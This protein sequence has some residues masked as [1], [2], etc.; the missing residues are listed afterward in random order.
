MKT[1]LLSIGFFILSFNV[2]GQRNYPNNVF[3][4]PLDIPLVLA[5]TFGELRNNH[6]HSGIDI[7]TKGSS[8]LPVYAIEEGYVS[9]IKITHGGYGKA[10]YVTHPN[11]FVSVY[12]H[13]SRYNE[14]IKKVARDR[15][16]EKE[17]YTIEV[18]PKAGTLPVKKGDIIAFTGNSGSST[19]P[20]LHFEIRDAVSQETINPLL[21]GFKVSDTK[22]PKINELF[23][24]TLEDN[25]EICQLHQ[26]VEL[27]KNN[28]QYKIK[29]NDTIQVAPHFG[30]ALHTIDHQNAATNKNGIYDIKLYADDELQYHYQMERF[31]FSETRYINSHIDYETK[32]KERKSIHKSFLDPNN[33]LSIYK[34]TNDSKGIIHF[35]DD[36]VHRIKYVVSDIHNNTSEL[37]FYVQQNFAINSKN[38]LNEGIYFD[39]NRINDF[40]R[41]ELQLYIPNK[42]LYRSMRFQ[43]EMKNSPKSCIAPLHKIHNKNT[44]LHKYAMLSMSID[45]LTPSLQEK[46]CIVKINED[47]TMTYVGGEWKNHTLFT[48]IRSFGDYSAS[49]D[50]VP[51]T[52]N[53]VSF[54][55]AEN[56]SN[57]RYLRIK[58][59]DDLS[60]IKSYK[61]YVD[62]EWVLMEYDSKKKQLTHQFT[63]TSQNKLKTFTLRLSDNRNNTTEFT[64][65]FIR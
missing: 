26:K 59:D 38:N 52:V 39:A 20:H 53:Y 25:G 56:L 35:N 41:D 29:A 32:Q 31:A 64:S 57:K 1:F 60:G 4:S 50:T 42:S 30:F 49:L 9:R 43:Y 5:G 63:S 15:Q 16:Y 37:E 28:Q 65:Q 11:G 10:L 44:P 18:F 23:V 47:N 58:I 8:G 13:L 40:H 17:S 19:A 2:F 62:D 45:S 48:K 27:Q 21:F 3:R 55:K 24:Y 6:F 46:A 36:K 12:A 22:A 33:K 61:A 54:K 7:K 51:P 34:D 14:V